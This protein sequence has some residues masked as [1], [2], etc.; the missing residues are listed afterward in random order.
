MAI[1][2]GR[3]ERE[4]FC[5]LFI[6]HPGMPQDQKPGALLVHPCQRHA[7]QALLLVSGDD[8]GRV[9]GRRLFQGELAGGH[10]IVFPA[11]PIADGMQPKIGRHPV[12]PAAYIEL[13]LARRIPL[14]QAEERLQG[15]VFC[16]RRVTH[17]TV[18][19]AVDRCPMF[20][21][22]SFEGGRTGM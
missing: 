16:L 10:L 11:F 6:R 15:Q 13:G 4:G 19:H 17:Q 2:A 18:K 21:E 8:L 9:S 12:E 1:D 20:P 7:D 14:G 3:R 22:Q 5:N